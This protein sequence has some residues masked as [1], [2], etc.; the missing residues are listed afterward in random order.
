LCALLRIAESH[1][2]LLLAIAVKVGPDGRYPL[3]H[4][5]ARYGNLGHHLHRKSE[6][7]GLSK[8]WDVRRITDVHYRLHKRLTSRNGITYI[9][10]LPISHVEGYAVDVESRR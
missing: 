1:D 7:A 9:L 4:Q 10:A 2:Y 3:H 5:L 8:Y 6:T